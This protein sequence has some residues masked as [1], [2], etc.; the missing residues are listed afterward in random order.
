MKTVVRCASLAVLLGWT[1]TPASAYPNHYL[2]SDSILFLTR[3]SKGPMKC[4][5][6]SHFQAGYSQMVMRFGEEIELTVRLSRRTPMDYISQIDAKGLGKNWSESGSKKFAAETLQRIQDEE[7]YFCKETGEKELITGTTK[8]YLC[9][10]LKESYRGVTNPQTME[11][12]LFRGNFDGHHE[13]T[14]NISYP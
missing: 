6:W 13:V 12:S 11:L 1:A 10:K 5:G 8:S 3:E 4:L 14:L 2:F 7:G 9:H